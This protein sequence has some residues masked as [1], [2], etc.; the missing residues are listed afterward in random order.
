MCRFQLN[1]EIHELT[2]VPLPP[3]Q[4]Y[5]HRVGRTGRAG[6]SGLSLTLFTPADTDFKQQLTQALAVQSSHSAATP[7]GGP[8]VDSDSSDASDSDDEGTK[9][10]AEDNLVSMM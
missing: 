1:V 3:L 6:Q 10:R 7:A 2:V 9:R 5:V 4:G 8:G